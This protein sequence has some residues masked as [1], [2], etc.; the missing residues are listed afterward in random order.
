[1]KRH[2]ILVQTCLQFWEEKKFWFKKKFESK[3]FWVG[4]NFWTK[5]ILG[6]KKFG[7][8]K[9]LGKKKFGLKKFLVEK[10]LVGLIPIH[11]KSRS[12]SPFSL[13]LKWTLVLSGPIN[14][15]LTSFPVT[16]GL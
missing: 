10:K 9:N 12:Y 11:Q 13:T 1:M 3:K 16:I 14:W 15:I 8:E 7:V 5:K 4:K 2:S 6:R